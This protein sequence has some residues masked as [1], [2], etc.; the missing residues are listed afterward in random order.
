MVV[1]KDVLIVISF[2]A[3]TPKNKLKLKRLSTSDVIILLKHV[4]I[5]NKIKVKQNK[6]HWKTNKKKEVWKIQFKKQFEKVEN[7]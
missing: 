3:Q 1:K 6:M 7:R 4:C 2:K 5:L